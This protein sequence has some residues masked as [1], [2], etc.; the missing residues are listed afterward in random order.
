MTNPAPALS[1]IIAGLQSGL[2]QLATAVTTVAAPVEAVAAPVVEPVVSAVG[3]TVA[4]LSPAAVLTGPT[5][6][7]APAPAAAPATPAVGAVISY[8]WTGPDLTPQT[9]YGI[10]VELLSDD[11]DGQALIAWLPPGMAQ[12]HFD[13]F[14]VL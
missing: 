10:V 6:P 13:A 11:S 12:L 14:S 4:A 1:D 5:P 7:P 2:A 3:P 9:N 8:E